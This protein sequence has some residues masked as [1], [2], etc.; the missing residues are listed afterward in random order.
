[1]EQALWL[2]MGPKRQDD[3]VQL[4][5]L[6]KACKADRPRAE[7]TVV[8]RGES[9]QTIVRRTVTVA[10]PAEGLIDLDNE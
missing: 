10:A 1:M 3:L 4:L 6:E 8:L 9:G 2:Q 7:E 5:A